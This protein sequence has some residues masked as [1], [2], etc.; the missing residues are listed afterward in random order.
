[1][2]QAWKS[3]RPGLY[4]GRLTLICAEIKDAAPGVDDN[5]PQLGWGPL[6][7][8]GI[9]VRGMRCHHRHMLDPEHADALAA[10][11]SDCIDRHH[12]PI[13][14]VR[15]RAEDYASMA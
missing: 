3:Y 15:E 10:I 2:L 5:D 13:G 6:V 9:N 11:L 8:G 12:H 4:A 14:P 1:M 7:E